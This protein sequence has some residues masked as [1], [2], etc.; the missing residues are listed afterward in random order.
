MRCRGWHP[1]KSIMSLDTIIVPLHNH[2]PWIVADLLAAIQ[3]RVKGILKTELSDLF[4]EQTGGRFYHQDEVDDVIGP[5]A[6]LMA[7]LF[8]QPNQVAFNGSLNICSPQL[9]SQPMAEPN[10][11]LR[12][13]SVRCRG[14]HP[15]EPSMSVDTII[16]PLHHRTP[17]TLR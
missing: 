14:R 15:K 4:D 8:F 17:C 16:I 6:Q 3:D 7:G 10:Q 12:R 11:T 13:I 9:C 2:T 1:K 5:G